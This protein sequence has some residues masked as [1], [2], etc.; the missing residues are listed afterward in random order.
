M[1]IVALGAVIAV[2]GVAVFIGLGPRGGVEPA[3][4]PQPPQADAS[5]DTD[6]VPGSSDN[7]GVAPSTVGANSSPDSD[8]DEDNSSDTDA[9]QEL[10]SLVEEHDQQLKSL[11][12]KWVVQL[13]AKQVGTEVEGTLWSESKVLEEFRDNEAKYGD[14][15]LLKSS[16]WSTFRLK[17]Y[18][19]TVIPTGY[20][21]PEPALKKCRDLQLD[22]D[23]CFAKL[24]STSQGPEGATKLNDA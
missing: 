4:Q 17:D 2:A 14:L 7:T 8:P 1:G 10:A 19:V 9:R 15:A 3:P 11:E 12:G 20:D 24:L 22:R 23:N 21:S 16:D 5:G 13:S 6:I 18:W